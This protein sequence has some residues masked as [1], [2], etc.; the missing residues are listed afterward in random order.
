MTPFAGKRAFVLINGA[1]KELFEVGTTLD[2][3]L[4]VAGVNS[5]VHT[6]TAF[7]EGANQQRALF[8]EYKSSTADMARAPMNVM[9]EDSHSSGIGNWLQPN[10]EELQDQIQ[11]VVTPLN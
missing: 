5:E 10:G 3:A 9:G 11:I 2:P 1:T 7:S 6:G 4:V 8:A